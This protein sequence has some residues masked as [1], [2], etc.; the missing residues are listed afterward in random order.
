MASNS[1]SIHIIYESG[2][3]AIWTAPDL[4]FADGYIIQ[5]EYIDVSDIDNGLFWDRYCYLDDES[6]T[7]DCEDPLY[8]THQRVCI[9]R[10]E[11]LAHAVLI[12]INGIETFVRDPRATTRCGLLNT[13]LYVEE[14]PEELPVVEVDED[15][16]ILESPEENTGGSIEDS[17]VFDD[18]DDE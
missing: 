1:S 4:S 5:G 15:G 7:G 17:L 8:H 6:V 12:E 3:Q 18:D 9:Q 11:D 13:M 2:S 10:G 16:V 14:S